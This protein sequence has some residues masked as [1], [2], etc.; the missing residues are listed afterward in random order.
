M[1]FIGL[2]FSVTAQGLIELRSGL[3]RRGEPRF[4]SRRGEEFHKIF[5]N[6]STYFLVGQNDVSGF[7]I[8]L[9]RHDFDQT[10][11]I[12][13]LKIEHNAKNFETSSIFRNGN[14][15]S[16]PIDLSSDSDSEQANGKAASGSQT[17]Q[18]KKDDKFYYDAR[19]DLHFRLVS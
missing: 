2:N 16:A 14:D 18:Q 13:L 1:G 17:T 3:M 6:L 9:K 10:L 19:K 11:L 5:E 4:F 12:R 8:I 15:S 7:P